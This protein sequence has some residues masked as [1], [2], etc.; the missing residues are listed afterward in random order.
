M[1][2][3]EPATVSKDAIG[4]KSTISNILTRTILQFPLMG[5]CC[6]D[7]EYLADSDCLS[8]IESQ[9]V[10]RNGH[11]EHGA[12]L[13]EDSITDQLD[14]VYFSDAEFKLA[15]EVERN[16]TNWKAHFELGNY[17]LEQKTDLKKAQQ[18]LMCSMRLSGN[19]TEPYISLACLHQEHGRLKAALQIYKKAIQK[20]SCNAS[21]WTG[22]GSVYETAR[23][24]E[25]A[26]N[27]YRI[28]MRLD[29]RLDIPCYNLGNMMYDVGEMEEAIEMFLQCL[30]INPNHEDACFNLAL[31]YQQ[32]GEIKKAH[33]YFDKASQLR[34]GIAE[35]ASTLLKEGKEKV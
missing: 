4:Q 27:A 14:E 29:P 5:C 32:Q 23:Q 7:L 31:C 34:L 8:R 2:S 17:L 10:R 3:T 13:L 30:T 22:L 35:T 25:E 28:A 16:P 15:L 11:N 24:F 6:E 18:H 12:F 19:N 9:G 1:E 26:I 20:D 21:L 33:K